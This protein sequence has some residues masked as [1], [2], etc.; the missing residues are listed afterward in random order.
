M[1]GCERVITC[2]NIVVAIAIVGRLKRITSLMVY[3]W[4]YRIAARIH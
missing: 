3:D 2:Y 4:G 1:H